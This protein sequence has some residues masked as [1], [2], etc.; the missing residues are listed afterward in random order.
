MDPHEVLPRCQKWALSSV[1]C[2][3]LGLRWG[4]S[5]G[6]RSITTA[7]AELTCLGGSDRPWKLVAVQSSDRH[8]VIACQASGAGK[9]Q[10]IT[11]PPI[12]C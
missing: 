1:L 9:R 5:G 11:W 8:C 10:L 12:W 3:L 7:T 6:E 2:H 4:G